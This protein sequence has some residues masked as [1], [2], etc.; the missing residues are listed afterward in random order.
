LPARAAPPHRAG[1]GAAD[2]GPGRRPGAARAARA[3]GSAAQV[4]HAPAQATPVRRRSLPRPAPLLVVLAVAWG[5]LGAVASIGW[6]P[7]LAW[8]VAGVALG[9]LVLIDL[10]LL[11]R[12]GVPDVA[13]RV[14]EALALGVEREVRL[15]LEPGARGLRVD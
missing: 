6:L 9:A 11:L 3:G 1:A 12:L 5:L 4:N 7:A 13:R 2:R 14:P 10:A 15:E 8:M